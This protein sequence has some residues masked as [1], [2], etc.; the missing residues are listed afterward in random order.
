MLTEWDDMPDMVD[1]ED[2][3]VPQ[4]L[5]PLPFGGGRRTQR[6]G[7]CAACLAPLLLL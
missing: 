7:F 1:N 5:Y 4:A 3:E 2:G 6:G